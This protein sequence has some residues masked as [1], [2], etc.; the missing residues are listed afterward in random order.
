MTDD[1]TETE[2]RK[3]ALKQSSGF[4]QR[5]N[6][7]RAM[8]TQ[9][10]RELLLGLKEYDSEQGLRN[11]RHRLREHVRHSLH[12]IFLL[13]TQLE[14]SELERIV[15]RQRELDEQENLA[16]IS[17]PGG[18]F[19]LGTRLA[20]IIATEDERQSFEET[21]EGLVS[22]A[23]RGTMERAYDDGV[24][25]EVTVDVSVETEENAEKIVDSLL[26]GTPQ[27]S[28]VL[29]YLS[30]HDPELLQRRLREEDEEINIRGANNGSIG[31]DHDIFGIFE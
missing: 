24:L 5:P 6:R 9:T 20:Y 25:T 31:P 16:Q 12:D 28:S 13:M 18:V 2:D 7:K 22:S 26:S 15:E 23:V 14:Q 17:F 29:S 19:N 30:N 11:A 3:T 1:S 21:V 27:R 4:Y 8:L 10:D